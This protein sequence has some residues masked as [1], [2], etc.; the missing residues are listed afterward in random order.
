MLLLFV[1]TQS[2]LQICTVFNCVPF[3]LYTHCKIYIYCHIQSNVEVTVKNC[4]SALQLLTVLGAAIKCKPYS[5]V[6]VDSGTKLKTVKITSNIFA[7]Q[8]LIW[9]YAKLCIYN[10]R[11][12]ELGP[13]EQGSSGRPWVFLDQILSTNHC[14]FSTF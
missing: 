3:P 8:S 2:T 4:K 11:F 1:L 7:V 10:M 5:E 13:P 12:Y 6:T 14:K 9:S